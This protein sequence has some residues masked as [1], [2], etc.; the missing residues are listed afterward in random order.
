MA[1]LKSIRFGRSLLLATCS[2]VSFIGGYLL[3]PAPS[4]AWVRLHVIDP[5]DWPTAASPSKTAPQ[6][7]PIE[8]NVQVAS[9]ENGETKVLTLNCQEKE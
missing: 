6:P 4:N 9:T 3:N 5:H 7:M 1:N 8:W 2:F